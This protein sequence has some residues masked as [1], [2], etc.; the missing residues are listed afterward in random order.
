MKLD[1]GSE[2]KYSLRKTDF[3]NTRY[4]A[5]ISSHGI[6]MFFND[7]AGKTCEK[8]FLKLQFI[9]KLG[10]ENFLAGFLAQ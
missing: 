2:I 6:S 10:G 3:R 5:K 8:K 1:E 4:F 7:F 9:F